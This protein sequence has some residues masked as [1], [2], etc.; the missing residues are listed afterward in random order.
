MI[1]RLVLASLALLAPSISAAIDITTCGQTVPAG[2]VGEVLDDL[3]CGSGAYTAGVLL[4]GRAT[5]RLNGHRIN[6]PVTGGPVIA[7]IGN[8]AKVL[9]PGEV[10]TNDG[11]CIG[12]A[13]ILV[14]EGGAGIDV[15]HCHIGVGSVSLTLSNV[16]IHDSAFMGASAI[17]MK[18]RD[19]VAF[20][21]GFG[22]LYASRSARVDNVTV[23]DHPVFGVEAD[24]VSVK[25]SSVSGNAR[26]VSGE[27]I[28]I[29]TSEI[30]GNS[31]Q[32]VN[33]SNS[34]RVV[35]STV[36]GNG[37]APDEVGEAPHA[38]LYSG[39]RIAVRRT[40][41]GT[42]AGPSGTLGVCAND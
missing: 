33:G 41:C 2:Q 34:V 10:D 38:D 17:R 6:G 5:L 7:G 16:T 24:D 40:T 42:S 20:G 15:H 23:S 19:V 26:G 27:R 8:K 4:E 14:V 32:G 39:D 13:D 12:G 22:G 36:T 21:N 30:T 11:G 18:A 29:S 1:R 35:R 3:D 31:E 25:S 9:G 37:F 28:T